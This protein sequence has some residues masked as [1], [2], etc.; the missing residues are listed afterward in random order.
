MCCHQLFVSASAIS[1]APNFVTMRVLR[2]EQGLLLVRVAWV[3]R[4]CY[5][6][7]SLT[8]QGRHDRAEQFRDRHGKYNKLSDPT[9]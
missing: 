9:N 4:S 1:A 2:A 8:D 5:S 6:S 3:G 7:L